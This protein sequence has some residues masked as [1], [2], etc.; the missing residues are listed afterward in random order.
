MK[1][2]N[3]YYL[4]S[5]KGLQEISAADAERY[6]EKKVENLEEFF[7]RAELG[8]LKRN[9]F[10]PRG[11]CMLELLKKYFE[12]LF[13]D[14]LLL[15][16]FSLREFSP[17]IFLEERKE[18]TP[19]SA[20]EPEVNGDKLDIHPVVYAQLKDLSKVKEFIFN[21]ISEMRQTARDF[22]IGLDCIIE[23]N[24]KIYK[25][26][27]EKLSEI[28]KLWRAPFIIKGQ[29]HFS[30][31]FYSLGHLFAEIN[32]YEEKNLWV[33]ILKYA[34]LDDILK[35]I[36]AYS[37]MKAEKDKVYPTFPLWIAPIQVTIFPKNEESYEKAVRISEILK[38]I[39]VR[40][41]IDKA[42]GSIKKRVE[43]IVNLGVPYGVI[44]DK[45]ERR[46]I[47]VIDLRKSSEIYLEKRR[48]EL[49]NFIE[50][51]SQELNG[52]PSLDL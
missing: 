10:Y 49:E 8:D 24:E 35:L 12:R 13:K 14:T 3:L 28:Y 25:E 27:K 43:R 38:K 47:T 17:Q 42:E 7:K 18:S 48:M 36:V 39:N 1:F 29:D 19:V 32:V 46:G 16:T 52:Y 34:S 33:L 4:V 11:R 30:I 31:H 44:V 2:E 6:L 51:V 9:I 23:V 45:E 41:S 5:E 21:A 50:M 40:V 26:I 15:E 22:E 20:F 37:K